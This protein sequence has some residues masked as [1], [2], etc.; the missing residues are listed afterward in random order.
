MIIG[1][2]GYFYDFWDVVRSFLVLSMFFFLILRFSMVFWGVLLNK[3][4]LAVRSQCL[5]RGYI[6]FSFLGFWRANPSK[7]R[8]LR[9]FV[10][11]FLGICRGFLDGFCCCFFFSSFSWFLF[12]LKR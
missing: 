9:R 5:Q 8:R 11:L 4:V 3:S 12:G 7:L 10:L 6:L 1:Y 2:L